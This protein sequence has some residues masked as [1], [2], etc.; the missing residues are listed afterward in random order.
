VE[1]TQQIQSEQPQSPQRNSTT[2]CKAQKSELTKVEQN[3]DKPA[4]HDPHHP[5]D[6]PH[7]EKKGIGR[8]SDEHTVGCTR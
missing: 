8:Q 2:T 1:P 7:A 4:D 3:G 6:I 5:N